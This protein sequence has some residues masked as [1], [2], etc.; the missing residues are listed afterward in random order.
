[1][2]FIQ[3]I[4][5]SY[6]YTKSKIFFIS[7]YNVETMNILSSIRILLKT[8]AVKLL[9]ISSFTIFNFNTESPMSMYTT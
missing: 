5:Y 9:F 1:M 4:Y 2:G 3:I 8:S 6:K 7:A